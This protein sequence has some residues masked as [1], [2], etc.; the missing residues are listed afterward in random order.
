[1]V[2]TASK[3]IYR[4]GGRPPATAGGTD[5]FQANIQGRR[6]PTRY[7]RWYWLLPSEWSCWTGVSTTRG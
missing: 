5:C 1:V 6:S 2:L 3:R 7:R 4:G